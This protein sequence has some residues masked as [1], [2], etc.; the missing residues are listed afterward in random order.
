MDKLATRALKD[1]E[2]GRMPA[3][4]DLEALIGGADDSARKRLAE[5]ADEVRRAH[6]GKGVFLRGLIEFS[7]H[8]FRNCKYCGIRG[9]NAKAERYRLDKADILACCRT[10]YALGYRTFVLQS[11]EDLHFTTPVLTDIIRA[12][13]AD[14]PDAAVTLSIGEKSREDY[15]ACFEAG[16]DRYLLR[17][18][19]ASPALYDRVHEDM[20]LD[21]RLACLETLKAIGYQIGAG[22]MVGLPGQTDRDL[23]EDILLLAEMQP[24]MVGIGP[25]IP[26]PDTPFAGFPGGGLEKTV[27]MLSLARLAV[28]KAMIP[29]T[30][31]LGTIDPTGREKGLRAGANVVMPNLSPMAVRR[32]YALYADKICTGEESAQ[33]RDG[34]EKRIRQ[35]GYELDMSR[36]DHVDWRRD[37]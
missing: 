18:E 31:A 5:K 14:F 19:T 25:F 28:P 22:F 3:A 2:K 6:Y 33:C 35:A 36:G 27:L 30:T 23:A 13:K 16:A 21:S 17:H 11:G 12:I 4:G 20:H 7:N 10:G 9:K 15:A 1:L 32:K 29:A 24:H 34:I 8:C 26:H 37:S